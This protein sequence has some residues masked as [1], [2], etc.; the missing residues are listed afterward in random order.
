MTEQSRPEDAGKPK[1]IWKAVTGPSAGLVQ[2]H[3]VEA[4]Q[5]QLHR[6][7]KDLEAQVA[8][9]L[10]EQASLSHLKLSGDKWLAVYNKISERLQ[11]ADL[12]INFKADNWFTTENHYDTYAQQY[13]R[14]GRAD[15]GRAQFTGDTKLNPAKI[16]AE[17]DDKITFKDIGGNQ[18]PGP[19]QRGLM[20]GR[21]GLDRVRGQM[22]FRADSAQRS[23]P[24]LVKPDNPHTSVSTTNAHFN[25]KTKQVFAA[26]N[27][28]RRP[29]GS[30]YDYGTSHLV[31]SPKFKINALYYGG[32]TFYHAD[33]SQQLAYHVIGAVVAYAKPVLVDAIIASCY[34]GSRLDDTSKAELLLEAHLF[35][36]VRFT[37]NVEQIVLDAPHG[38]VIHQNARKFAAKHGAR[39]VLT[40][41][42]G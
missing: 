6:R 5:E 41:S 40:D 39:L 18:P 22:E 37:S 9:A 42:P 13:E 23:A 3:L 31:L 14:S 38:S 4:R 27:Y 8:K 11:S 26:L 16:R 35:T 21:Q 29:H 15:D 33:A 36:E 12:T 17:A 30:N 28:G 1:S 2:K 10:R 7:N 25:P 34:C 32:D 24:N 20:P 19:Q